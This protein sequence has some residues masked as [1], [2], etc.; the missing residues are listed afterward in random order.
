ME[1]GLRRGNRK[2][3]GCDESGTGSSSHLCVVEVWD[4]CL[5]PWGSDNVR[6]CPPDIFQRGLLNPAYYCGKNGAED[7]SPRALTPNKKLESTL[8][9]VARRR[10]RSH[11]GGRGMNG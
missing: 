9:W 1:G 3:Y 10:R 2:G 8:D 5:F 11:M 4:G 7:H 6:L